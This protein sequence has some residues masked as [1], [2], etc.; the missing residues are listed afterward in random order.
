[1]SNT[2]FWLK[3]LGDSTLS[4][5]FFPGK[6][7]ESTVL[8]ILLFYGTFLVKNAGDSTG[9]FFPGKVCLIFESV[10]AKVGINTLNSTTYTTENIIIVHS[11]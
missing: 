4:G 7:L 2:F 8:N 10:M 6:V 1:M 3:N 11:E 5:E 9:D